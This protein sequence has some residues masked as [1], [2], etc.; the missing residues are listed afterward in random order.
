[1][2]SLATSNAGTSIGSKVILLAN[3]TCWSSNSSLITIIAMRNSLAA[4]F[5]SMIINCVVHGCAVKTFSSSM[6]IFSTNTTIGN[7][8][9]TRCAGSDTGKIVS[10]FTTSA[11]SSSHI[12][13]AVH[14]VGMNIRACNT[15]SCWKIGLSQTRNGYSAWWASLKECICSGTVQTVSSTD[16]EAGS[17]CSCLTCTS[18]MSPRRRDW[19]TKNASRTIEISASSTWKRSHC[20]S[21]CDPSC[22][23]SWARSASASIE[24]VSRGTCEGISWVSTSQPW[25]MNIRAW[26]TFKGIQIMSIRTGESRSCTLT[27]HPK[28]LNGV[29]GNARSSWP[30]VS[31]G[32]S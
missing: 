4:K 7:T 20:I 9:R 2:N 21:A 15:L 19:S 16:I 32:T 31:S 29:T 5:T 27:S 30:I 3:K 14:T 24:E 26:S 1:L 11:S 13:E 22:I 8:N 12:S 23:N 28:S 10:N 25:N 18:T 17:T 6:T